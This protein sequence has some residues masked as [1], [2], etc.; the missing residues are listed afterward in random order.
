MAHDTISMAEKIWEA[1][2]D[3]FPVLSPEEQHAGI[4]ILRELSRGE[5]V[6]LTQ[7]A[8]TLGAP[9]DTAEAL[10]GG[11]A[12]SPFILTDEAGRIQS[13][14]GLS[15][16]PTHHCLR[17]GGRQLWAWCASDTLF[18]PELLGESATI[19][20]R[21]PESGQLVRLTVTPDG[22][23]VSEPDGIAVSMMP[24]QAWD[25]FSAERIM[26]SAC[27]F[28]FFFASPASGKRWQAA[29]PETALLTLDESVMLAKRQNAWLFGSQA[30]TCGS[31]AS[32]G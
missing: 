28:I 7:V 26:A 3:R 12:L 4:V 19:E 16:T 22:V 2:R 8:R 13:F 14:L 1:A 24:P 21:D 15:V 11:S 29:H 9:A 31:S 10:L 32:A 25:I 20:S 17:V 6:T 18:L 23:G 5:A 27:H 30:G